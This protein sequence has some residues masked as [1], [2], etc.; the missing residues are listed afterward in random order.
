MNDINDF[1]IKIDGNTTYVIYKEEIK[2][3]EK[4]IN[5]V[6]DIVNLSGNELIYVL[7]K[8][9]KI[10]KPNNEEKRFL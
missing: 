9:V 3:P 2:N 8:V 5:N 7:G 6:K 4:T 10:I 1:Q